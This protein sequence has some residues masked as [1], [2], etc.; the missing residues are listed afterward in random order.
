MVKRLISSKL[1]ITATTNNKV[2]IRKDSNFYDNEKTNDKPESNTT[3]FYSAKYIFILKDNKVY[4]QIT[5]DGSKLN[6]STNCYV[7]DGT[8]HPCYYEITTLTTF[9]A[10]TTSTITNSTSLNNVV[11]KDDFLFTND[12]FGKI[13]NIDNQTITMYSPRSFTVPSTLKVRREMNLIVGV[14]DDNTFWS[15]TTSTIQPKDCLYSPSY[16]NAD[17]RAFNETYNRIISYER[18]N[19]FNYTFNV[20]YPYAK[21]DKEPTSFYNKDDFEPLTRLRNQEKAITDKIK[22]IPSEKIAEELQDIRVVLLNKRI[23][24][25]TDLPVLM[26]LYKQT[27]IINPTV[28]T[29]YDTAISNFAGTHVNSSFTTAFGLT[30]L[31]DVKKQLCEFY[32]NAAKTEFGKST[33]LV[34]TIKSHCDNAILYGG[35]KA[36]SPLKEINAYLQTQYQNLAN[37]EYKKNTKNLTNIKSNYDNAILYGGNKAVTPLKEINAYLLTQFRNL[38][39]TEYKKT[40]KILTNIKSNYDNAILY[41]GNKAVTPLKEINAYLLTQYQTTTSTKIEDI[42]STYKLLRS[43][44]GDNMI[45]KPK[46]INT[47]VVAANLL[48]DL[49]MNPRYYYDLALQ[50]GANQGD[51]NLVRLYMDDATRKY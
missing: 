42:V 3:D 40:T 18:N 5:S 8:L 15:I 6:C 7:S 4:G 14:R 41:G 33:R 23:G 13:K 22:I 51:I 21:N 31:I 26:N 48:K 29:K 16:I 36:V 19:V 20:S 50:A 10:P 17:L 9:T 45:I 12:F 11:A 37:T 2:N 27:G 32:T 25:V 28:K 39:D 46:M 43:Y 1:L 35:N 24:L 49:N 30:K 47:C 38:A 34:Q 44:G